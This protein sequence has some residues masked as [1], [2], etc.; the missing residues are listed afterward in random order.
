MYRIKLTTSSPEWPIQRQTPGESGIW[1]NCQFLINTQVEECD[2]WVVCDDLPTS[3]FTRCPPQNTVLM[4]SEPPS[5]K[6]YVPEFLQ[7]FSLIITCNRQIKASHVIYSHSSLPWHVGRR[8]S[9]HNNLGFSKN[10]D[11]LISI[12]TFEKKRLISVITS[13]KKF[14][15]GHRQRI[16][17]VNQLKQHFG[18][19]LDVFGRESMKLKINGMPLQAINI[20]SRSKTAAIRIIGPKN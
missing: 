18:P 6:N 10:Y 7:Q 8:S 4:T 2:Y 12:E 19:E 17:F 5:V 9:Q 13:D 14:T 15:R 1:G 20:I 11:E 3:Q 16:N